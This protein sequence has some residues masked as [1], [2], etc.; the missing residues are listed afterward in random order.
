MQ[1]GQLAIDHEVPTLGGRVEVL[2]RQHLHPRDLDR[3]QSSDPPRGEKETVVRLVRQGFVSAARGV[4]VL[5]NP[6]L[7]PMLAQPLAI[8]KGFWNSVF[9]V[10]VNKLH[11]TAQLLIHVVEVL[12]SH[13]VLWRADDEDVKTR[14]KD[15]A[16]AAKPQHLS[17]RQVRDFYPPWLLRL[18]S[19][20][21]RCRDELFRKVG[22]DLNADT[23]HQDC[24]GA[25]RRVRKLVTRLDEGFGIPRADREDDVKHDERSHPMMAHDPLP[26][27]FLGDSRPL[28]S[29]A[30]EGHE[31]HRHPN[32]HCEQHRRCSDRAHS[33]ARF[34]QAVPQVQKIRTEPASDHAF[35]PHLDED[36]GVRDADVHR[37]TNEATERH[38]AKRPET[39]WVACWGIRVL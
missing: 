26:D 37:P 9:Q 12:Q 18:W 39:H 34:L 30:P 8:T 33:S 31:E 7:E 22:E 23:H 20:R 36:E 32:E 27:S 14:C 10:L 21:L 24:Q 19:V 13:L 17:A 5:C 38:D 25:D 28:G 3:I 35:D 1:V 2:G 16:H 4:H 6:Q 29:A 15:G 11:R